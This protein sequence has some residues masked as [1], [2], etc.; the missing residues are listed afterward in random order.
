MLLKTQVHN[1]IQYMWKKKQVK[2]K[3]NSFVNFAIP[4][5]MPN[6]IPIS[7]IIENNCFI[8]KNLPIIENISMTENIPMVENV[9]IIEN[10]PTVNGM[11]IS[12]NVPIVEKT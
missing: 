6:N 1:H 8:V 11:P 2:E 4:M 12:K 10:V 9:P 3:K 7:P 5:S